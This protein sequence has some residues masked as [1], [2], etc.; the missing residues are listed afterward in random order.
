MPGGVYAR[1]VVVL[2]ENKGTKGSTRRITVGLEAAACGKSAGRSVRRIIRRITQLPGGAHTKVDFVRDGTLGRE[3]RGKGRH[4]LFVLWNNQIVLPQGNDLGI[5]VVA[6]ASIAKGIAAYALALE[7]IPDPERDGDG[8]VV[9]HIPAALVKGH[10]RNPVQIRI[11][12]GC[13]ETVVIAP[14]ELIV[15]FFHFAP[16]DVD[17]HGIYAHGFSNP[18][19]VGEVIPS[20]LR[21]SLEI[22][23][24]HYVSA[25]QQSC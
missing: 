2:G 3:V 24:S 11:L 17:R 18:E 25:G 10:D 6:F 7:A 12:D 8:A 21:A 20:R 5:D 14:V 19:L 1:E 23:R 15:D 22:K 16:P 13:D 4:E 9:A